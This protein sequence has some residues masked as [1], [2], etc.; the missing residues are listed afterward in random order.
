MLFCRPPGCWYV[1]STDKA[2]D[3][4]RALN[5]N[6]EISTPGADPHSTAALQQPLAS[7][8]HAHCLDAASSRFHEPLEHLEV[9]PPLWCA[10]PQN[11][12]SLHL[13]QPDDAEDAD[14][15]SDV[16]P[17]CATPRSSSY[18]S[19][20]VEEVAGDDSELHC[21]STCGFDPW[22]RITILES[23]CKWNF[24][25]LATFVDQDF[26]IDGFAHTFTALV[27]DHDYFT[28]TVGLPSSAAAVKAGKEGG[29]DIASELSNGLNPEIL[30][31]DHADFPE[32]IDDF[33]SCDNSFALDAWSLISAD[34]QSVPSNAVDSD[35]KKVF[36]DLFETVLIVA[37]PD[38]HL[39]ESQYATLT[40]RMLFKSWD[41]ICAHVFGAQHDAIL[42]SLAEIVVETYS[43]IASS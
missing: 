8:D 35:Y 43:E 33:D 22:D 15:S 9:D 13:E 37:E 32:I 31:D 42:D 7:E 19:D 39:A 16:P 24:E 23:C 1:D 20:L 2:K 40:A 28:S 17:L 12:E 26:D 11:R 3:P 30:D 21:A 29:S 36:N 10:V 34:H 38:G 27:R 14:V 18:G 41:K 5:A 6:A 25:M 4:L